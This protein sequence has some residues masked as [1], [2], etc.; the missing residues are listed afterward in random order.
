MRVINSIQEIEV[1]QGKTE[2]IFHLKLEKT[3]TENPSFSMVWR[4]K[5]PNHSGSNGTFEIGKHSYRHWKNNDD[6]DFFP[7]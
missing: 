6:Q 2:A 3:A 5:P 4:K 7:S 1:G